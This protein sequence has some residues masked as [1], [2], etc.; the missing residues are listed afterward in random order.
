MTKNGQK[1]T[2]KNRNIL[3]I[4]NTILYIYHW[5]KNFSVF[6]R[7]IRMRDPVCF[8][9]RPTWKVQWAFPVRARLHTWHM[10]AWCGLLLF[11]FLYD[12]PTNVCEC[13]YTAYC[14]SWKCS[15]EHLEQHRKDQANVKRVTQ[16]QVPR[17][18][19]IRNSVVEKFFNLNPWR[20]HVN[21]FFV[22]IV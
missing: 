11:S 17:T 19:S 5:L 8:A 21:T 1:A 7:N 9:W 14:R 3:V 4:T 13:L 6:Q 20:T 18:I 2:F 10:S 12:W 22:L 15:S 16:G